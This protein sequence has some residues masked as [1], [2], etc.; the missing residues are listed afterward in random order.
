MPADFRVSI[1]NAPGEDAYPISSFTWMLLYEDAEGQDAGEADGRLHEVGAD[2]RPEVRRRARLRAAAAT[3]SS[4]WNWKRSRQIKT[5]V[6]VASDRS[7]RS[8][9][10]RLPQSARAPSR[11][12]C[13]LIV[14]GDR[15]RCCVRESLLSIQEFGWQFWL[16]RHVGSGRGRVR[17][18]AVHLGHALLVDPGAAHRR[19]RSRSASRS[20]SPSCARPGSSS[21]WCS[22]PSC[23]RRS[24]RSSTA[25]GASSCWCRLC[26]QLETATAG[27][28]P[29]PAALQ[30]SAA[31]RRHAVGGA[32][33]R[34]HGHPLHVVGR[35]RSAE[36]G[37]AGAARGRLCARRD[38]MG[39]HPHGALL[40]PDR[41]R[42]RHHARL[43]PRARRDDGRD[44]G[45]R[46]QPAVIV[47]AV[48]AAVHDGGGASPTSSPR[49]PTT[50][51]C[52]RWSRSAW[53]CSSS[54]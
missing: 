7:V 30:R 33:P 27:L 5:A 29:S 17:R 52:T 42:R 4:R 37:A 25:S 22:S 26:A 43:R 31:R 18:A 1:T 13:S 46:Q 28:A 50:C 53:C 6:D 39:S 10:L 12:S 24:R 41:H 47:V 11:S 49:P 51:T 44:D 15:L 19:R 9:E 2:R 54:R 35:A 38:A 21:R 16:T 20:Y 40:R 8:D 36:G 45:H 48:R 34:H 32:D 14:A 23:S 3:R